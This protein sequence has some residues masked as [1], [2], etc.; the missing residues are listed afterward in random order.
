MASKL[1]IYGASMYQPRMKLLMVSKL[2]CKHTM[3]ETHESDLP[4]GKPKQH[5][6]NQIKMEMVPK[7]KRTKHSQPHAPNPAIRQQRGLLLCH[8]LHLCPTRS[9]R[10]CRR[11]SG[12]FVS[13]CTLWVLA[14]I[15]AVISISITGV[16]VAS[17]GPRISLLG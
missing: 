9:T 15:T 14:T 4:L 8:S 2:T 12:I 6:K 5:T 10:H 3:N 7:M 1:M 13:D 16:S 11:A 17:V